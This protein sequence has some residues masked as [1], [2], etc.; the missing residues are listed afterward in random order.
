[1]IELIVEEGANKPYFYKS[2][3]YKRNDSATVEVDNIELS[4]LVLEGKNL[5]FDSTRASSQ[6]L[7]FNYFN[8]RARVAFGIEGLNSDVMKTLELENKNGEYSVAAELLADENSFPGIDIARFGDSINVFLDRETFE[9]E[10]VLAEFDQALKLF[11]RYYRY[12]EVKGS[13]RLVRELVPEAAYR[14]AVANALVHRHWDV[15]A[16]IRVSMFADRI[17]ITSP[18]GLPAEL[19]EREYK[20]GQV[21]ILRNPV[22]GNVFFRLGLIERFG[23]GV[24]RIKECY[25]G[26]S[27]QPV[28][29]VYDNSIRITLPVLNESGD[30]TSDEAVVY[31]VLKG[32]TLPISEIVQRVDFGKTK[33]S[34]ILNNLVSKGY[35]R[36]VGNGRGTKYTA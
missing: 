5:T 14:E 9:K 28:F 16:H 8:E 18:G 33:T 23:T 12:E 2:K 26:N 20:E 1:M 35:A 17:E 32:K 4:R 11:G 31:G 25:R 22:L 34:R 15:P 21:S 30:L 19:S 24:L 29:D 13:Q 3:A 27:T 10:S 6:N 7:S 36:V